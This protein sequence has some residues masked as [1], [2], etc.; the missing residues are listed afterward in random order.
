MAVFERLGE[1]GTMRAMGNRSGNVVRLVMTECALLGAMGAG[2]GILLGLAVAASIS[3]IG[4]PMPPPPNSNIGYTAVVR[5]LPGIVLQAFF[6]GLAA[7]VLAG[8]VPAF[9]AAKVPIAEALRQIG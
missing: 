6:I 4:I 5:L 1:F 8:I 7:G 3:A 9:R 2:A